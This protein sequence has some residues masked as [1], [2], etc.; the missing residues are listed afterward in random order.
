MKTAKEWLDALYDPK[1]PG[2]DFI[3]E[4]SPLFKEAAVRAF[5]AIQRDALES[6]AAALR[7]KCDC[8]ERIKPT[9][10]RD[11]DE[12]SIGCTAG[13]PAGIVMDFLRFG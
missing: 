8:P 12:H 2:E 5:A 1:T 7:E 4:G 6:A 11:P 10:Q 13:W 9:E 3:R